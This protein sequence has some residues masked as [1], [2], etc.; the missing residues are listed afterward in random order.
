METPI[1][2]KTIPHKAIDT[3]IKWLGVGY[4]TTVTRKSD[5]AKIRM[6]ITT[7]K[8]AL[9]KEAELKMLREFYEANDQSIRAEI[10]S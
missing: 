2:P 9:E 10:K 4:E 3:V 5:C 6:R 1:D 8:E 7:E